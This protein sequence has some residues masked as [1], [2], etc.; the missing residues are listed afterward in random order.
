VIIPGWQGSGPGHW[1]VWLADELTDSGRLVIWPELPDVDTPHLQPWLAALRTSLA[2]LP[3]DGYDV[4]AHSLGALLWLHHVASATDAPRADRVVLVS[5][6]SPTLDESAFAEFLP[7]P[8]DIDTV[9]HSAGGTVLVGGMRDP[10]LPEGVATEYGRPLKIATTV[11]DGAHIN[12]EDGHG[13]WPAMLDWC[14]RDN[15]A[16]Y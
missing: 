1:Q 6:P 15:L 16:F 13:A 11:V 9:R 4:V 8:M 5:P 3:E 14:G 10:Y 12:V 2:G 7:A